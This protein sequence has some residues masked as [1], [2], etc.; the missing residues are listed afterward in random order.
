MAWYNCQWELTT[1]STGP[2]VGGRGAHGLPYMKGLLQTKQAAHKCWSFFV[3]PSAQAA[4][5][6]SSTPFSYLISEG[7]ISPA[8][9]SGCFSINTPS[10]PTVQLIPPC[11]WS[12]TISKAP[13]VPN[14]RGT[15]RKVPVP[16]TALLTA[17]P[18]SGR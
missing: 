3:F 7:S 5:G 16:P 18:S 1:S 6:P 9:A 13:S 17:V 4:P 2:W 8:P 10:A 14:T 15:D 12:R 11:L